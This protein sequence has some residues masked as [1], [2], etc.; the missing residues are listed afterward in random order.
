MHGEEHPPPQA[1][2]IFSSTQNRIAVSHDDVKPLSKP[3]TVIFNHTIHQI[4]KTTLPPIG[5]GK[6]LETP[7]I[8]KYP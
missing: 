8:V 4:C 6:H 3:I 5:F 2:Q 1:R 7:S